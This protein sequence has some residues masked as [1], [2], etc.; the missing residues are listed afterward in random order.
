MCM[1]LQLIRREQ[2]TR[3]LRSSKCHSRQRLVS[4][5]IMLGET[6]DPDWWCSLRSPPIAGANSDTTTGTAACGRHVSAGTSTRICQQAIASCHPGANELV[7]SSHA[8]QPASSGALLQTYGMRPNPSPPRRTCCS[9]MNAGLRLMVEAHA[10]RLHQL[11][12]KP[13]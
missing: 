5:Q 11:P 6:R 4:Y 8:R 10:T 7:A 9:Q 2:R 13:D 1:A 12:Q 3:W